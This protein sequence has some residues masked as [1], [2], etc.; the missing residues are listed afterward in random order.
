MEFRTDLIL[1]C[2]FFDFAIGPFY[3]RVAVVIRLMTV[4]PSGS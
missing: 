4:R 2:F 1:V 3:Q